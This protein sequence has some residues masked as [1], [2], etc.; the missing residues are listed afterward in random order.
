MNLYE[1]IYYGSHGDGNAE[2]TIYLVRAS[3]FRA[4]VEHAQRNLSASD[5]AGQTGILADVVYEIGVDLSPF[6]VAN[7]PCTIRGPYFAFAYNRGWKSW[8]R[9]VEDS[10]HKTEWIEND[11]VA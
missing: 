5:H 6:A 3:D 9:K 7:H 10:E 1:V 11:V 8:K 2:D 4:A